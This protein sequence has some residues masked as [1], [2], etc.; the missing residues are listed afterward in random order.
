MS[1]EKD[2]FVLYYELE[3]Q[4]ED[5]SD[6]QVGQLLRAIFEYEKRKKLPHFSDIAVKT[7]FRFVATQLDRNHEKYKATI[8]TR[9]RAGKQGGRPSTTPPNVEKQMLSDDAKKAVPVPDP[10]PVPLPDPVPVHILESTGTAVPTPPKPERHK[11]GTNG[12]VQLADEQYSRLSNDL[13]QAEL[14]RCIAYIDESAQITGNKNKWRDWNLVL[15]KCHKGGWGLGQS[16]R[17]GPHGTPQSSAQRNTT[18]SSNDGSEPSPK[19]GT[20]L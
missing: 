2:S 11:H 12:W 8:E 19:Y 1:T 14:E 10:A 7:A 17:G 15:R 4:T 16:Q 13:G 18:A 20:I 9:R 3:E 5:F 6:A